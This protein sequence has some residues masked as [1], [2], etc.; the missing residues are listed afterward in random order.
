MS[1]KIIPIVSEVSEKSAHLRATLPKSKFNILLPEARPMPEHSLPT[2]AGKTHREICFTIF[3]ECNLKCAFCFVEDVRPDLYSRESLDYNLELLDEV[4]GKISEDVV[5]IK[6]AGG[7]L[8]MDKFDD[9]VFADY[10]DMMTRIHELGAKYGK[11][12]KVGITTNMIFKKTER[13][14]DFLK[15]WNIP[16]RGSF[17]LVGRFPNRKTVELFMRNMFAFKEAGVNIGV[18]FVA[19]KPN[20]NAIKNREE[21]IEEFETLYNN[22]DMRFEYYSPNGVDQWEVSEEEVYEWFVYM[23]EHY[24]KCSTIA[25]LIVKRQKGFSGWRECPQSIWITRMIIGEC[26]DRDTEAKKFITNKGCLACDYLQVCHGSCY[27]LFSDNSFCFLRAFNEY[28][29]ARMDDTTGE[30]VQGKQE[31]FRGF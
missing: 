25:D 22:F 23:Y 16:I 14:I 3:G 20:M 18:N 26:C 19:S 7:E 21:Y 1:K 2:F 30:V 6:I 31:Q 5:K 11:E 17:D 27:R 12:L 10:D 9:Q 15:R 13:V 8:F 24:P 29:D 28:L 4:L